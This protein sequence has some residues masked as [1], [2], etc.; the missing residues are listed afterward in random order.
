MGSTITGD[1]KL[2]SV[3]GLIGT[4][5]G[6]TATQLLSTTLNNNVIMLYNAGANPVVLGLT[7]GV[8]FA[9]AVSFY[10]LLAGECLIFDRNEFQGVLW[11]ICDTGL[12]SMVRGLIT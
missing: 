4:S 12:S 5:A 10:K 2:P 8:T 1:I 6:D 9:G 3:A 11:G 7:N